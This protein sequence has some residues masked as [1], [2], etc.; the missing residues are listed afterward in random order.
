MSEARE[1]PITH[2][3][4]LTHLT[5]RPPC[6]VHE[7]DHLLV[8]NKPA[9]WNTHAPSPFAGEGIYDWLRHREPRWADLAIIHRLDKETSGVM[10]FSK[11]A[12]SN[13]SLTKQFTERTV[14]K[15]YILV[16]DR[17]VVR[18][19]FSVKSTLVRVGDK[20]VS[21]PPHAGAVMA[22]TMFRVLPPSSVN[23][24]AIRYSKEGE[25]LS[26]LEAEPVT[27]RTH[28]IRAHAAANG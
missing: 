3:T 23:R 25:S 1:I 12:L 9:G 18:Q 26:L 20:F 19:Q 4:D 17:P 7:D 13:R 11:T 16:T 10:V 14:R 28:Q 2:L 5:S 21:R 8:V 6:I 15:R 24:S 22:E 27:G